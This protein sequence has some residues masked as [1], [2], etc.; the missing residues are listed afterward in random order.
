MIDVLNSRGARE[1]LP[2]YGEDVWMKLR[3]WAIDVKREFDY[4]WIESGDD[5]TA[6][7]SAN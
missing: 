5:T 3:P 1:A 6:W 2:Y 4:F 7:R